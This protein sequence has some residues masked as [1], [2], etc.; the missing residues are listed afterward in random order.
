[1]INTSTGGLMKKIKYIF[2]VF[3]WIFLFNVNNF[4][5]HSSIYWGKWKNCN[6]NF[7]IEINIKEN[8]EPNV[9]L[10]GKNLNNLTFEYK[11]AK[12]ALIPFLFIGSSKAKIDYNLYL[13][14]G[15]NGNLKINSKHNTI[16]G[17]LEIVKVIDNHGSTSIKYHPIE[18]KRK[19]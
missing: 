7:E 4:S 8:D 10:N 15:H 13:I 11:H 2:F 12:G 18:L 1:M 3:L 9:K 5:I 17:F 6:D 14:I 16:R 19:S